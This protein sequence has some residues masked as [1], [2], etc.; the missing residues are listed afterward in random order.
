M[1]S[2]RPLSRFFLFFLMN[3]YVFTKRIFFIDVQRVNVLFFEDRA[4]SRRRGSEA[5]AVLFHF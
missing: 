3:F 2:S 5:S 1:P 4:V